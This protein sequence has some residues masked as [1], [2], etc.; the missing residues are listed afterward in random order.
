MKRTSNN[1]A[2]ERDIEADQARVQL[3]AIPMTPPPFQALKAPSTVAFG[4]RPRESG[5]PKNARC[6]RA[7]PGDGSWNGGAGLQP[8]VWGMDMR[9]LGE[10]PRLRWIRPL[11]L[12]INRSKQYMLR[13]LRQNSVSFPLLSA[14]HTHGPVLIP[15]PP[16]LGYRLSDGFSFGGEGSQPL[17]NDS[18]HA[19]KAII[20]ALSPLC[21][22]SGVNSGICCAS[23]R[24]LRA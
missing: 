10:C 14:P 5:F 6:R 13:H 22:I 11:A 12:G 16:D 7:L 2:D 4:Q 21:F 24:S 8:A 9:S 3:F 18:T 20:P 1:P 15:A 19:A 17:A 23:A